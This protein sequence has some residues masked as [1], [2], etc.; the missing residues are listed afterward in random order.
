VPTTRF[1]VFSTY[2]RAGA[3]TRVR[4]YEWL[5]HLGISAHVHN[6]VGR[7]SAGIRTLA[8][9]PR[10]VLRAERDLRV[11]CR[12]ALGRVLISREVSPLSDGT[13]E[14]RLLKTAELG[15]FDLDDA[16]FWEPAE[17][18]RGTRWWSKSEKVARAFEAADCVI[19]GNEI[20]AEEAAR[21]SPHVVVIPSCV[22]PASYRQK[23]GY[24]LNDPPR[25]LWIGST[26]TAQLVAQ[27][28]D[29]LLE[30]H[31]RTGAR[32]VMVGDGRRQESRLETMIDHVQWSERW[33]LSNAA[34]CDIGIMPLP[35]TLFSR[36]KCGYKLLQ[37][38]AARIPM[39]GSAVGL[40][41]ELLY[42]LGMPA[43][44]TDSDWVDALEQILGQASESREVAGRHA[45]EVVRAE[46]SFAAWS[47]AWRAAMGLK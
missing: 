23:S 33:V 37:Y 26:S 41:R 38:A 10:S 6:Y 28:A 25:I 21:W 4:V 24:D 1:D 13:L 16:L 31:R 8:S 22:Q 39:V 19:A 45:L 44:E 15:V 30:V 46:Y 3:S 20:L 43:C 7:S 34:D 36:G 40:N 5:N 17:A 12:D 35:D 14:A 32:L 47:D 11:L 2:G 29:P 42:K 27:I 18:R 9:S